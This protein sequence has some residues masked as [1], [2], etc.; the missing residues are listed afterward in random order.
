MTRSRRTKK[1]SMK[2]FSHLVTLNKVML[3]CSAPLRGGRSLEPTAMIINC[4]DNQ[5]RINSCTHEWEHKP[6]HCITDEK[7]TFDGGICEWSSCDHPKSNKVCPIVLNQ[8][9]PLSNIDMCPFVLKAIHRVH[10]TQE[11]KVNNRP[12]KRNDV[13]Q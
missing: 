6:P 12:K 10:P 4:T 1:F 13:A 8:S 7:P 9:Q 5:S 2:L 3:E 11:N